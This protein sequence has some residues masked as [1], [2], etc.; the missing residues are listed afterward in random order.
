MLSYS[1]T[2]KGGRL[3]K[4]LAM[5]GDPSNDVKLIDN[6]KIEELGNSSSNLIDNRR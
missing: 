2:Y 1:W 4:E 3:K 6:V 5:V